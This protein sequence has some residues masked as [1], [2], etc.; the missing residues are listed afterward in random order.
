MV[1]EFPGCPVVR[2]L[3]CHYHRPGVQSLIRE[4]RSGKL[5]SEVKNKKIEKYV[6]DD[7]TSG[8]SKASLKFGLVN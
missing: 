8:P 7:L 1:A 5:C 6:I 2:T 3:C 4:L